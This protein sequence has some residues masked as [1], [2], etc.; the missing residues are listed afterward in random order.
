MILTYTAV[1]IGGALGAVSR[2]AIS[3]ALPATFLIHLP[4][5][6]LAINVIGCFMMGLLAEL[7]A[8]Y[9][10]PSSTFQTFL[11]VG[12]LG[13]FTTFSAFA[14]EFA[15]LVD[16]GLMAWA[17]LY[18]GLSVIFSLLGFF[19]GMKLIKFLH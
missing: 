16:R 1:A 7:F 8:F 9:W 11:T 13:G 18:A 12:F 14:L 6:M 10:P 19:S 3:K 15:L 2:V 4:F 5:Q 17:S